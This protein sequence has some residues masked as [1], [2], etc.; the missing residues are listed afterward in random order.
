[1]TP[2]RWQRARQVLNEALERESDE[3]GR[4]LA[5]ACF[6]D[7]SL[8]HE[9]EALLMAHEQAGSFLDVPA[10]VKK[11]TMITGTRLGPYEILSPIGA[12]G[13]GQ[14]YK[15]VSYTHLTLPTILRV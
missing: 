11:V 1:M 13:M 7:E 9:V 12:G 15:A 4:F 10:V 14:V 5:E 8:R 3:R 6:G 2:E